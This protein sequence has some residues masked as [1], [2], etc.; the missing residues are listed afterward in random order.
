[1]QHIQGRN[2]QSAT[3]SLWV[4]TSR[5]CHLSNSLSEDGLRI[6]AASASIDESDVA[7][8]HLPLSSCGAVSPLKYRRRISDPDNLGQ[9]RRALTASAIED[10]PDAVRPAIRTRKIYVLRSRDDKY[11]SIAR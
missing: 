10:L 11:T 4:P 6:L 1:M 7:A 8:R 3:I 9:C 2:Q 5:H